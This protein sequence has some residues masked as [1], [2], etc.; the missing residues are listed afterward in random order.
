MAI[1]TS[2]KRYVDSEEKLHIRYMLKDSLICDPTFKKYN[3]MVM[4]VKNNISNF[5]D[6]HDGEIFED[7]QNKW[8][9]AYMDTQMIKLIDNYSEEREALLKK[10]CTTLYDD[11]I[12]VIESERQSRSA[13]E[14]LVVKNVGIGITAGS[15][16]VIVGGILASEAIIIGIGVVG[17]VFGVGTMI[18]NN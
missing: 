11:K 15:T 7:D 4:Y 5:Y 1:E 18:K 13:K 2:F 12:R 8:N 17:V 6:E 10:I 9:Y 14:K 16:A 3:E